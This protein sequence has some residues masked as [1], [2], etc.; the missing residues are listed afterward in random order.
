MIFLMLSSAANAVR[1]LPINTAAI[2]EIAANAVIALWFF[3]HVIVSSHLKIHSPLFLVN[4]PI[5]HSNRRML[6]SANATRKIGI[7]S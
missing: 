6:T 1:I 2:R 7:A 4:G 5:Y 3:M